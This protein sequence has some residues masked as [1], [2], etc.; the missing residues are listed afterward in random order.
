MS[1]DEHANQ[2]QGEKE[3]QQYLEEEH[4]SLPPVLDY[5]HAVQ[6]AVLMVKRA[7]NHT[8]DSYR[9]TLIHYTT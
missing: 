9:C 6:L 3:G 1:R 2:D 5:V 8:E 4:W 7:V